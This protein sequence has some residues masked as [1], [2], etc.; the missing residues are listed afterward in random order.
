MIDNRTQKRKLGDLGEDIAVRYLLRQSYVVLERNF[1]KPYGE[2]DIVA[3]KA[4]RYVFVEVKTVTRENVLPRSNTTYRAEDN[5]HPQ[6]LRRLSNTILSYLSERSLSDV[7]WQLDVL[8]VY[9]DTNRLEAKIT[10]IRD[11]LTG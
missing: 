6:K 3:K 8:A 1:W 2:I 9:I 11:C 7:S 4:E 10:H 5:V